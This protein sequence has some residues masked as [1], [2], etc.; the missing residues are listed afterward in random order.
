M[1]TLRYLLGALLTLSCLN[2]YA[3][4]VDVKYRGKVDLAYLRCEGFSS[5]VVK[6]VCFD[7]SEKYVIVKLVDTYYHY[8]G[9]DE[10][11]MNAWRSAESKGR[12]FNQNIKGNFDCRT[13]HIPKYR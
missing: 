12:F 9:I 4:E 1:L 8:C 2:A 11:V 7:K 3:E 6:R 5:S 10:N 13:G